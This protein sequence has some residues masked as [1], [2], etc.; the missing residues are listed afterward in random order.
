MSTPINGT[1]RI[2]ELANTLIGSGDDDLLIIRL[3]DGTG[4]K[5][6]KV[7]DLRKI[8]VGDFDTLETED[9]T[10]LIAAINE[11]LGDI[12]TQSNS[13]KTLDERTEVLKY[14]GAGLKNSIWRGKS[15]GSE[16][17]AEQSAA[18]RDGSFKDL[19]LGDYW[20]IGGVNYRIMDFDYWYQSGD[21]ACAS[22]HVV[23][24]PDTVLYNAQMNTT[25]V[26]TGGYTGSAM[27]T[28]N[29]NQAKTTIKNAFGSSHILSHR[30][31]LT[32]AVSNGNS[33]G[34]AWFDADIELMNEHM[35]YGARA[36]GGGAHVG[37][38]V[39]NA[40]SQLSGFRV[41]GDLEHTRSGWYW[42]RDVCSATAFG[43]VGYGGDAGGNGASSSVGVR[44]AFPIY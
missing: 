21:T 16:F 11:L 41:H 9:K 28:A 13:I 23:I 22:H 10:G 19:W 29:L 14:A 17:T 7:A 2:D 4:T 24:V 15:L 37:Y 31:L 38:D 39:G 25:N 40:K 36:W 43:F 18:I 3:A 30:E 35:V 32:N 12:T 5:N 6:I 26:T 27:R 1:R 34:W 20:T 44:P 33:S 8:L 42:L